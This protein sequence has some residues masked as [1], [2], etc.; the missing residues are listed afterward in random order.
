MCKAPTSL[1][2]GYKL[3][4]LARH[5]VQNVPGSSIL[6]LKKYIGVHDKLVVG[7]Q[8]L[9]PLLNLHRASHLACLGP[10]L[11]FPALHW[12]QL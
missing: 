8:R 5:W 11:V 1:S 12:N 6:F 10:V 2:L 4:I 9:G 3:V 7:W